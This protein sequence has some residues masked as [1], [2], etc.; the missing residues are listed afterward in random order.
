M[1]IFNTERV[2]IVTN[3]EVINGKFV[4]PPKEVKICLIKL[5]ITKP[6]QVGFGLYD[7]FNY[8]IEIGHITT[9]EKRGRFEL[10]YGLREPFRGQGYMREAVNACVNWLFSSGLTCDI[11]AIP[12]GNFKDKS[13]KLLEAVGFQY[14]SKKDPAG[15]NWHVLSRT[16]W[17]KNL[18]LDMSNSMSYL[19]MGYSLNC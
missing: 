1:F 19:E 6:E 13:Q 7:R 10:S 2:R 5:E 18:G 8:D 17:M 16:H 15:I 11:C 9:T 12:N 3:G 4:F 14:I